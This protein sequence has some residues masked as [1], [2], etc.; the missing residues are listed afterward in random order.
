M[1]FAFYPILQDIDFKTQSSSEAYV[2]NVI[3]PLYL[4]DA[5][6][7]KEV[8]NDLISNNHIKFQVFPPIL[9]KGL[10]S[11]LE[12]YIDTKIINIFLF[13]LINVDE[14]DYIYN[15]IP[16]KGLNGVFAIHEANENGQIFKTLIDITNFKEPKI[17]QTNRPKNSIFNR[18]FR[19]LNYPFHEKFN[20]GKEYSKL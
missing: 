14:D 13:G 11:G 8:L 4:P 10:P 16:P 7:L 9:K 2:C 1:F 17:I 3:T 20:N 19:I 6:N 15:V 18:L 5:K 12:R